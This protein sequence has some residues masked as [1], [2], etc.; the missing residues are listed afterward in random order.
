[1][2]PDNLARAYRAIMATPAVVRAAYAAFDEVA[3]LDDETAEAVIQDLEVARQMADAHEAGLGLGPLA[4]A[5]RR[6]RYA[7]E[8]LRLPVATRLREHEDLLLTARDRMAQEH[9][10]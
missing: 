3:E 8:A 5:I 6:V 10:R 2:T 4:T 1:M 9:G 7:A